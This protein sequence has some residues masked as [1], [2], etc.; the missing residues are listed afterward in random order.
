MQKRKLLY[1]IFLFLGV[2]FAGSA[3]AVCPVCVIAV[4]A[5]VGLCRWLG[6]DDTLSG[7]WIG[8]LIV[9]IIIWFLSWLSKKQIY[10]VKSREAGSPSAKF[11]WVNFKFAWIVISVLFYILT[12][13]PLYYFNIMGH[14]LNKIFGIDKLL[15][16]IA[17]GSIIFLI[18]IWFNNFLKNK[19]NGRVYFPYQKVIIPISFLLIMNVIFYFIIKCY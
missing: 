2:S 5:G 12:I 1:F 15:F 9:S 3:Y 11:N 16:G 8:G 4:G 17:V 10:P 6:I 7:L 14:P 19:N 13:W 18:S